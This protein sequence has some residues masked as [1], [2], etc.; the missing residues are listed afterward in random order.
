MPEERCPPLLPD[1][2]ITERKPPGGARD[3]PRWGLQT[4]FLPSSQVMGSQTWCSAFVPSA[5][6]SLPKAVFSFFSFATW[7]ATKM[8]FSP[9]TH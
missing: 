3:L 4:C 1:P 2:L 5:Q 9:A 6:C 7:L 8:H